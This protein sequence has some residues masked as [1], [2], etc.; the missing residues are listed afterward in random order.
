MV[1]GREGERERAEWYRREGRDMNRRE[2]ERRIID[3]VCIADE[4]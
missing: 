2:I 3:E 1:G 4:E